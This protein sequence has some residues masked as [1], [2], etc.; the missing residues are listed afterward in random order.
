MLRTVASFIG[1][2]DQFADSTDLASPTERRQRLHP[3][4]DARK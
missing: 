3:L 4:Y 1:G 2:I